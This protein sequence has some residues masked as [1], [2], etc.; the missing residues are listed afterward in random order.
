MSK[1]SIEIGVPDLNED[2]LEELTIF[3]EQEVQK[4][5]FKRIK[6]KYIENFNLDIVLEK[7]EDLSLKIDLEIAAINIS[8]K[9]ID[10]LIN[11][12]L[13]SA[14]DSLEQKLQSLKK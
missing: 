9:N 12:A 14:A 5:I 1:F 10:E 4:R 11:S 13:Q 8:A 2:Q 3:L 7:N 6:P